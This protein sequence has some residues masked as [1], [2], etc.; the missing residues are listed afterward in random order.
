MQDE[1]LAVELTPE[2]V[3]AKQA[4]MDKKFGEWYLLKEELD[5]KKE[6]EMELRNEIVRFY[7]PA[8]L[9]EGINK[10]DLPAGWRLDATG[11]VNRKI[12]VTVQVAVQQ[13]LA[14]KF[15]FDSG[16]Y[17][18]YE[19]KLSV[20]DYRKIQEAAAIATDPNAPAKQ[21]LSIFDQM[22]IV[23]DGSP[24]VKVVPPKKKK[25]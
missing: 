21:L 2:Q 10:A 17:I 19:P 16:E 15:H 14:E 22:L 8:G 5:A 12:D 6:R 7:F 24:Q 9:K 25:G 3:A 4:E 13:E 18:K 23:T 1:T 20:S 11:V